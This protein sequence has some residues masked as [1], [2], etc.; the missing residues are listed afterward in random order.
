M[1]RPP[2]CPG[3]RN[4]YII[5]YPKDGSATVFSNA[6]AK[7]FYRETR[8]PDPA[9]QKESTRGAGIEVCHG[10]GVGVRDPNPSFVLRPCV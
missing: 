6:N 2:T 7:N 1:I 4:R 8:P 10:T 5:A 9:L 3:N